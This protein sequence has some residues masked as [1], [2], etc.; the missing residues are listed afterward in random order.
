MRLLKWSP[1]FDVRE[2]SPI[3]PAWI[4]F[5]KV[6]LHFFNMQ[7]L[8]GLASLFGR[9]LQTDQATASLSRPSV[10]RVLIY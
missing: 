3:A 2:E 7:I 9:P 6:H 1:N 5:P 10:A 8:F 4:S